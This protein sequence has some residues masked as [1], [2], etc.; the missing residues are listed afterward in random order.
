MGR[1]GCL[2]KRCNCGL[3]WESSQQ[4]AQKSLKRACAYFIGNEF[5][6]RLAC[7]GMNSN[8]VPY[9][10]HR[11]NQQSSTSTR[12]NLNWGGTCYLTPL[13]GAFFVDAYLRRYWTIA[14]FSTIYVM[15]MTLLT[16]SATFPGLRPKCYSEDDCHPTDSQS[17]LAFVS[18]HLIPLALVV[19]RLVSHPVEQISLMTLMTLRKK[20]E[21]FLPFN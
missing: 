11:L 18:R 10:K 4:K 14:C 15:G 20:H 1:G 13:I 3:S 6:E 2:Y 16:I 12:N 17:A 19:L 21:F 7:Y 5:C 8:L 9:F